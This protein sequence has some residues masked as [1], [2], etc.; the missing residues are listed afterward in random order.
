MKRVLWNFFLV[1]VIF[2][3]SSGFVFSDFLDVSDQHPYFDSIKV[4]ELGGVVSG[5]DDKTFRPDNRIN[6]VEFLK[7][8]MKYAGISAG[9]NGC[10]SD[11]K[12]DWYAPYVCAAKV[13]GLVNGYNDGTFHPERNINFAEASKIIVNALEIGVDDVLDSDPWFKPF[14]KVLEQRLAI[15][16]SIGSFDHEIT[17]AEMAEIVVTANGNDLSGNERITL[18]YEDLEN[19][20]SMLWHDEK[21]IYLV[22]KMYGGV[23]FSVFEYGFPMEEKYFRYA[24]YNGKLLVLDESQG[25]KPVLM[26]ID[27]ASFE[28]IGE[29]MFSRYV[30]A[31]VHETRYLY[32]NLAVCN[33]IEQDAA[34]VF[35]ATGQRFERAEDGTCSVIDE[36]FLESHEEWIEGFVAKDVNDIFLYTDD[37][38]VLRT[39]DALDAGSFIKFPGLNFFKDKNGVYFLRNTGFEQLLDADPQTVEV[40]RFKGDLYVRDAED[41]WR[42]DGSDITKLDDVVPDT[43]FQR[44]IKNESS[45][46][47]VKQLIV[48]L[49]PYYPSDAVLAY[50][51][52]GNIEPVP[53]D[54]TKLS[55]FSTN[56]DLYVEP[57]DPEIATSGAILLVDEEFSKIDSEFLESVTIGFDD[58]YISGVEEGAVFLVESRDGLIYKLEVVELYKDAG[59]MVLEY[60]LVE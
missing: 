59:E 24:R 45:K 3:F 56:Y 5:Y 46:E 53:D 21:L 19:L 32:D 44:K 38:Y 41:I 23:E 50:L 40:L 26:D 37:D 52:T 2:C 20:A 30:D 27:S 18:T 60:A 7:I 57:G 39:V 6:R 33:L 49:L 15:P 47:D 12:S 1:L 4:L 43:F 10:F 35:D 22:K 42:V 25:L 29:V 36:E 28:I 17:R 16:I 8:V 54:D 48:S 34:K 51:K 14:V 58:S 11:V 55:V 13:S 31:G 9:G